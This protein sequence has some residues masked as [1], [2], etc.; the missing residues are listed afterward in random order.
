[1]KLN[2]ITD[3]WL[4]KKRAAVNVTHFKTMLEN[5]NMVQEVLL[6]TLARM[7]EP[8]NEEAK[9]LF[10][11]LA[12]ILEHYDEISRFSETELQGIDFSQQEAVTALDRLAKQQCPFLE[13]YPEFRTLAAGVLAFAALNGDFFTPEQTQ[14]AAELKPMYKDGVILSEDANLVAEKFITLH[15]EIAALE[16][17]IALL[18]QKWN[19]TETAPEVKGRDLWSLIR[20]SSG[21]PALNFIAKQY[22]ADLNNPGNK[23]F[24]SGKHNAFAEDHRPGNAGK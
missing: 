11:M 22:A 4:G 1:L 7:E 13:D 10:D 12:N 5:I 24:Y 17:D 21:W 14:R 8:G 23:V 20:E 15:R 6:D 2:Y 3:G 16:N 9:E 18:V 19:N